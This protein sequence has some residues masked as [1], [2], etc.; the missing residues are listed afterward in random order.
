MVTRQGA[1]LGLVLAAFAH[2]AFATECPRKI[3][4]EAKDFVSI[5]A[6]DE[7]AV[8]KIFELG[9]EQT[10][11]SY[12]EAVLKV[13]NELEPVDEVVSYSKKASGSSAN[14]AYR[15]KKVTLS[16]VP[17]Q[18]EFAGKG[19][20]ARLRLGRI[21][22]HSTDGNPTSHVGNALDLVTHVN[23]LDANRIV[24]SEAKRS[25][26]SF[27]LQIQIPLGDYGTDGYEET[28]KV[29][30]STSVKYTVVE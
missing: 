12:I 4:V 24:Q 8:T 6:N 2:G 19:Y 22:Y 28:A 7:K 21:N 25:P 9:D 27:D 3:R 5:S 29:G 15:G 1:V 30:Y 11:K 26:L 16:L 23:K 10:E 20:T 13:A 18:N 14:C 17:V